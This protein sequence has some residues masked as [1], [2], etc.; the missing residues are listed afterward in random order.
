MLCA[1]QSFKF[2]EVIFI[3]DD[4]SMAI[5]FEV[6]PDII[7]FSFFVQIFDASGS[8]NGI[9]AESMLQVFGARVVSVVGL[10]ESDFRVDWNV[11]KQVSSVVQFLS[12]LSEFG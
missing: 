3:E 4:C 9:H 2:L 12:F 8:E 10:D 7:V 11:E 5:G 6:D 1:Q